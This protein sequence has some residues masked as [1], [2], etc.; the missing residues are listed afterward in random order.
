MA[1]RRAA[2]GRKGEAL[3][4]AHLRR[5]GYRI[6]A[7]NWACRV[8]ELDLVAVDGE[9]L[10]FVEVRTVRGDFLESPTQAVDPGKQR[11]VR[12]TA[13]AYLQRRR[14]ASPA[15]VR[16]DV[17]GI[18]LGDGAPVLEHIEDAF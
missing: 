9:A 5:R 17:I 8:G 14:G 13:D 16:F 3:A 12:R 7:R 11:R 10:V 1:D 15:V 18:R 4:A 2:T 6:E